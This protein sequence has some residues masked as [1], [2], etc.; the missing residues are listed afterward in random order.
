MQKITKTQAADLFVCVYALLW[1]KHYIFFL[2]RQY[3][4]QYKLDCTALFLL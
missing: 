4:G 3:F 2:Q 1:Q